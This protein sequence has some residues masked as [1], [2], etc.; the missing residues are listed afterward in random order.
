LGLATIALQYVPAG[1]SSILAFTTP[2]W[3]VPGAIWFLGERLG[4]LKL[5]GSV[6]GIAGVAVMFNP[7]AFDWNDPDTLLG[8]GFLL[9]AA[10][11]WGLVMLQIRGHRWIG[12]P[13]SL[14]P[15]Q[16]SIGAIAL[17]LLMPWFEPSPRFDRSAELFAVLVYAGVFAS[18]FGV[19]GMVAVSQALPSISVSLAMPAS[20]A[21]SVVSAMILLSE[22]ITWT[23]AGGLVLISAGLVCIALAERFASRTRKQQESLP[24]DGGES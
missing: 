12:S 13:L 15:W 24:A 2:I 1:R 23:N 5:I 8:N 7:A 17:F 6:F 4:K 22:P 10:M 9:L 16:M 14:A 18:A 21:I 20:P 11:L 3:V 19:W